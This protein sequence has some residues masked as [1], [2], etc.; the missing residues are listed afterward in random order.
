[1]LLIGGAFFN[2]LWCKERDTHAYEFQFAWKE[3]LMHKTF[4][5]FL[6]KIKNKIY[7]YKIVNN[8]SFPLQVELMRNLEDRDDQYKT[9]L[10]DKLQIS[11][12]SH[13]IEAD[14]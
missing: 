8:I 12:N 7:T 5:S 14:T 10:D 13:F 1:M 2:L 11:D 3:F 9:L 4:S 6:K